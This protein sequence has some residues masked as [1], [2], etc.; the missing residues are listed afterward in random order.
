MSAPG[1][2]PCRQIPL[3]ATLV[4][5]MCGGLQHPA[6]AAAVPAAS[7]DS[8]RAQ[9]WDLAWRAFIGAGKVE[10]AYALT[11]KAV[12]ARPHSRLWLGRLAEVARWSNHP[13]VALEALCRLALDL[14]QS[15]ELQPALD[16]AIGLGDDER[17]IELLRELIRLGSATPAQ[18]QM[19]SALYEDTGEPGQAVR[20]LQRE[21]ARHPAPQLL[22]EQAVIYRTMGDPKRELAT[23]QSYRKRFGPDPQV[24][25]TIATIEYVRGN[26]RQALDALLAAHSRARPTNTAYW[27]TLSGLAWLLERYPL[28][29][30]AAQVLIDTHKADA[31]LYQRVV[32][33]EQ[34]RH[35]ERAFAIAER[36]WTQTHEPALFMAMLG[37]ASSQQPALPWLTRAFALLRPAQATAFAN[38]PFYWTSLAELR[39]GERRNRAALA[40]YRHALRLRPSDNSLL[41]GYLW[42]L[43]DSGDLRPIA[44]RLDWLSARAGGAPQLWPPL[45]AVYETLGQPERA[46]PWM[47]AQWL[48]RRNDPL[49]L[50]DYADTLE[51][52]D[53]LEMAWQLR[54]RAYEL[55]IRGAAPSGGQTQRR[56]IA[57]ARLATAL[58]PG[59]PARGLIE[60]LARAPDS[61]E[62]RVT[63]LAWML[64]ERAYPLAR[65]WNLRAFLR[66]PPP[67]WAQLAQAEA[68]HDR[69]AI[70]RL[71][72][73]ED[74]SL[75]DRERL[76]AATEL[77]W[78]ARAISLAY[79]G[80]ESEPYDAPLRE[81]FEALTL[82]RADTLAAAARVM[83]WSGL[84]SEEASV[85]AGSWVLPR[86]RLDLRLDTDRQHV[87]D[88]TQLAFAPSL[89]RSALLAWQHATE[90]GS[91]TFDLGAGRNLAAW[92]RLGLGWSR[93]WSGALE[94]TLSATAGA[95][96]LDT[97][98]LSI[99]G[100]EDRLDAGA[101]AR[102]TA[103]TAGQLE[104][105]AGRLR[106]Q[107]GGALGGVER[108]SLEGGYQ[109]WLSP[110][111]FTLD[112]SLT[113]A[114]YERAGQLPAQLLP[115]VPA[116]QRAAV[117]FLVPA[118]FIQACGGGHLNLGY[119]T[120]Y[121]AQLRPFAAA[122]L[123]TNSVSGRGY[124]LTAG[125][126]TAV[127]GTDHLSLSLD[128]ENNVGTHSG[129]T[130]EALLRYRH[131]FTPMH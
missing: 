43:I 96:P 85:E 40:A 42:L 80:L 30:R 37:V 44:P 118:S 48:T 131:Y 28:A 29:A 14:H 92:S 71:L 97:A 1:G 107:G 73:R 52:T 99:A 11:R 53:R 103:R 127:L 6:C 25:L 130:T 105:E 33:A 54:R 8:V 65:W 89:G 10:D 39:A 61:P 87:V 108:F 34:Y 9:D 22:W 55:L 128:L 38:E 58:A 35:P 124:D 41:A 36:G 117:T 60:R 81:Q 93:R 88:R 100:L 4:L 56:L 101:S 72:G 51:Q 21:F 24:M 13:Q 32:Y 17:A 91:L 2:L 45:A 18:R 98:A 104:L 112:A 83:Q 122:D 12:K 16:L 62:A 69:P 46:L 79:R 74:A 75:S 5:L 77:G 95:R 125:I 82:P 78:N 120:A 63:V 110:P 121:T 67:D 90:L 116:G 50:I 68:V 109:L 59:D 106:A 76:A 113:G 70:A 19:L 86:D 126:A 27:Q 115:L 20:E 23:L 123:C 49:W 94:T 47:Q 15:S 3:Y 64:S 111:E 57:L 26:L 114:H 66:H 102:L 129:R 31:S 7:A 119:E 84:L